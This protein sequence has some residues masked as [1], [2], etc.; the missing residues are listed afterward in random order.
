[1]ANLNAILRF[2][3]VTENSLR[4]LFE[5]FIASV[6]LRAEHTCREPNACELC[7]HTRMQFKRHEFAVLSSK[8]SFTFTCGQRQKWWR[9]F[10]AWRHKPS[11]T[12]AR[13]TRASGSCSTFHSW[14]H[15]GIVQVLVACVH[16]LD[17]QLWNRQ[18]EKQ[19]NLIFMFCYIYTGHVPIFVHVIKF[20][21][22]IV[23]RS[24]FGCVYV[25]FSCLVS[26]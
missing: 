17:L 16:V 13:P 10:S 22:L 3:V 8:S 7:M 2:R 12:I 14:L 19:S 11:A 1:M 24:N 18:I 15:F 9:Y 4:F 6:Q 25:C 21:I 23:T 26:W 5:K 20:N